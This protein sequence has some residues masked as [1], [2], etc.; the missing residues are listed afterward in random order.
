M[1][2]PFTT[3]VE[4]V[5]TVD[6]ATTSTSGSVSFFSGM[7][8]SMFAERGFSSLVVNDSEDL[9]EKVMVLAVVVISGL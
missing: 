5:A 9:S 2:D 3:S 7:G 6:E 4:R 1:S 8:A